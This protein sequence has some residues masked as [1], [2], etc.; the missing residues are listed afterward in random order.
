M[1]FY[2]DKKSEI[3]SLEFNARKTARE[4][5]GYAKGTWVFVQNIECERNYIK[6]FDAANIIGEFA[7]WCALQ[8]IDLWNAP[9]I[10]KDYLESGDENLRLKLK[11]ENWNCQ[12]NC[13]W[14]AFSAALWEHDNII[15]S[16]WMAAQNAAWAV[17][18]NYL[19]DIKAYNLEVN[20]QN[21]KLESMI[22]NAFKVD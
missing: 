2:F 13:S 15:N 17:S 20:K 1:Y 22:N 19:R 18:N 14:G 9:S 10:A 6:G 16:A 11:N 4:A 5:L 3:D 8:V 7:R 12:K 21:E